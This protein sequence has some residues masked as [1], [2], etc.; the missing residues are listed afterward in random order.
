MN[1]DED[2]LRESEMDR[3]TNFEFTEE[4]LTE[5]INNILRIHQSPQARFWIAVCPLK[6]H[7]NNA[8][9]LGTKRSD[10]RQ[11]IKDAIDHNATTGHHVGVLG[12]FE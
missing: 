9:W 6:E 3:G 10:R 11:A 4:N 7:E 12:P 8:T 5:F 1:R 2:R